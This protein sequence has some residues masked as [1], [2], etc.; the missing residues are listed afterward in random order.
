MPLGTWLGLADDPGL[1]DGYGPV[2]AA[3]ARQIA[4]DAARDHPTTTTWRCVV[5]HD[6][7]ATVLGVGDIVPTP[8]YSPTSRQRTFV[9]TADTF[10][11]FPGC[12]VRAWHCDIDHRRP[13]DHD[14]PGRGGATCTCN[15][16]SLCRRHH[17]LKT[18]GLITP[19]A[20]V[21]EDAGPPAASGERDDAPVVLG[22]IPGEIPP[23]SI[24]WRTWTGRRYSYQPPRATPAPADPEVVAACATLSRRG[25][26]DAVADADADAHHGAGRWPG[27][28]D[29]ALAHWERARR[30]LLD[31]EA[32]REARRNRA[33]ARNLAAWR[34]LDPDA[35]P[36]F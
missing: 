10:C 9:R 18:A 28:E 34:Q 5:V 26:R 13:Y 36:P 15:L 27:S 6:R 23:G 17:R 16:A 29:P 12:R 2:P 35:P 3:L 19:H 11:V 7:H 20:A 14:N 30:R 32:A 21:T 25:A 4:A 8:R 22:D 33:G 24:E 31:R 1:L